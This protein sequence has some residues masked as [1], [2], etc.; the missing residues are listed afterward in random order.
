MRLVFSTVRTLTLVSDG[1]INYSI[2]LVRCQRN[3]K[4]YIEKRLPLHSIITGHAEQEARAITRCSHRNIVQAYVASF[5]LQGFGH[6]SIF[7][8]YCPLGS[9][10][11]LILRFRERRVSFPEG[12]LW[13]VLWDL[14]LALAYLQTGVDA[15]P[16]AFEGQPV[17]R[18][19]IGWDRI[20][21]RDIKPAN[22][23][24][25][26]RD[27]ETQYPTAV[28]AN[29]G[30][31]DMSG[32]RPLPMMNARTQPFAAP[33]GPQYHS[34]G[35]VYSVALTIHYMAKIDGRPSHDMSRRQYLPAPRY[36]KILND[37]LFRCLEENPQDRPDAR[38]LPYLVW[39]EMRRAKR[40]RERRGL[41]RETLP[42]WA[43]R[44]TDS[45]Q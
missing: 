27:Q 34:T 5:D 14:S 30:C 41:P 17:N 28:L 9:L 13:K 33:E 25:T 2:I 40:E 1:R 32:Y 22:I 43:F 26:T 19:E 36:C 23:F 12:F 29:F 15:A 6:G 31:S 11:D 35:D 20:I 45:S 24:F 3:L 7:M 16:R 18:R 4:L 21:H 42:T 37:L 38:D 8:E 44:H 10:E 39:R